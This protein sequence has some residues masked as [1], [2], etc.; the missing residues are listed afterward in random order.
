[1]TDDV[2]D[3]FLSGG[4]GGLVD[5][6]CELAART[7][8]LPSERIRMKDLVKARPELVPMVLRWMADLR[9]AL[10]EAATGR[11]NE[12]TAR[13]A[14]TLVMAAL[15][16]AVYRWTPTSPDELAERLRTV[17]ADMGAL[18]RA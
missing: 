13:T 12:E 8:E 4:P 6:L 10:V 16:E 1:V 18:I 5:D 11:T 17:V 3:R 9:V 2:R 14:A 15:I 7:F